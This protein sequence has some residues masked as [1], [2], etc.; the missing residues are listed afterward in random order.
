MRKA[1]LLVFSELVGGKMAI[2]NWLN[3]EPKVIHWRTDLPHS[4]YVISEASAAE[5]SQSLINF[6]GK[7]GRYLIAE[8]GDNRQGLL[9]KD[10][11][12]LLREKSRPLKP[13][14]SEDSVF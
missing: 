5:L 9:P 10:T 6:N 1:Y 8:I 11:W 7:K 12:N 13:P 4:F 2:R 3:S 14:S